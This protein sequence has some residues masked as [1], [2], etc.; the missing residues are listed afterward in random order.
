[1]EIIEDEEFK[2]ALIAKIATREFRE[3]TG[4]HVSDLIYCLDK[5]ALRR[6]YPKPTEEHQLL[7]YSI[8]WAT[9]R[10]LTGQDADMPE[11][12]R[13]GIIVTLDAQSCEVDPKFGNTPWE[14]KATF[15]S[16]VRPVE[17]NVPWMRQLMA[18]CYV[19]DNLSAHLSRLCLMGNWGSIFGK[20]D[21]KDLPENRK[22]TISTPLIMFSHAE[23]LGNWA[24]LLARKDVF[25]QILATKELA[26]KVLAIP[27]GQEWECKNCEYRGKECTV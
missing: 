19:T 16:S 12:T 4:T 11:S 6:L 5:S 10:W 22:P 17:E 1:M 13:D 3:R 8:G 25:E 7:T 21:E 2:K 23:L 18:Q 15:T 14:L 24:W 27:S 26:P 9:Q 20:K